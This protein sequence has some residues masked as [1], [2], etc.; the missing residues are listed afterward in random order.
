MEK[1]FHGNKEHLGKLPWQ[2][3]VIAM[4]KGNS[5]CNCKNTRQTL[6]WQNKSF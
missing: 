4:E 5:Y 6:P 3:L 2:S 1:K